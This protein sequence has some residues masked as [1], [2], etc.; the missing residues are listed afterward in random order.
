MRTFRLFTNYAAEEKWLS[1]MA[2]KGYQLTGVD[3]G[4]VF[5]RG[6]PQEAIIRIDHRIFNHKDDFANY[7]TLFE[8]SGWQHIA[9]TTNTGTQYFRKL[10]PDSSEDIFSDRDSKAERYKRLARMWL[11]F[12]I[13]SVPFLVSLSLTGAIDFRAI[14]DP[15]RLYLT[16]GLWS[17]EGQKFQQAF[18]FETPFAVFRALLLYSFPLLVM[19]Y[20]FFA[21]QAHRLYKKEKSG[22]TN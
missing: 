21:Y 8:D 9:G 5:R 2:R 4:Y 22:E 17:F 6:E 1:E 10:S 15:R 19:G 20:A 16:P 7:C 18:W 12:C 11:S 13:G 14:L 3:F